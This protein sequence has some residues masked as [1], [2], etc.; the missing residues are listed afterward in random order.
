MQHFIAFI[1]QIQ[2]DITFLVTYCERSHSFMRQTYFCAKYCVLLPQI[3]RN[4]SKNFLNAWSFHPAFL[5][6]G[7]SWLFFFRSNDNL[8][9]SGI[10]FFLHWTQPSDRLIVPWRFQTHWNPDTYEKFRLQILIF[11]R[12]VSELSQAHYK[13]KLFSMAMMW[14]LCSETRTINHAV[15]CMHCVRSLHLHFHCHAMHVVFK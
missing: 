10:A 4:T 1:N 7:L 13:M 15:L 14:A 6:T 3:T 9:W 12:Q 5:K 2:N 11:F 8:Q